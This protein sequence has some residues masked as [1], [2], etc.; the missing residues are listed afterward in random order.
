VRFESAIQC[1]FVR[2]KVVP[3]FLKV[4]FDLRFAEGDLLDHE[5]GA[6]VLLFQGLAGEED[7]AELVDLFRCYGRIFLSEVRDEFGNGAFVAVELFAEAVPGEE[8]AD[9]RG[10]GV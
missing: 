1:V 5:P 4:E 2:L 10:G 3:V 6:G 9:A 7:L 8:A